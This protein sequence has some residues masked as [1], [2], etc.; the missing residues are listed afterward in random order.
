MP[1]SRHDH[2]VQILLLLLAV[3]SFVN[4]SL[5]LQIDRPE[6]APLILTGHTKEVTAVAWCPS[7]MTKIAT[8]SDDSDLRLWRVAHGKKAPG[9]IIDRYRQ[10]T[11]NGKD[12]MYLQ[13]VCVCLR[14]EGDRGRGRERE[15]L[16]TYKC[17]VGYFN[18]RAQNS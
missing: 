8:C 12:V 2:G 9:E 1:T 15:K 11:G 4:P 5:S 7:D 13:C 14:G 10:Y 16:F 17:F 18:L 3:I 6:V